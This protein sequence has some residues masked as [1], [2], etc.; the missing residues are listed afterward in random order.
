MT[1]ST[2]QPALPKVDASD[3]RKLRPP[4]C[5]MSALGWA[6]RRASPAARMIATAFIATPP[7]GPRGIAGA[8]GLRLVPARQIAAHP[9]GLPVGQAALP[10]QGCSI[11]GGMKWLLRPRATTALRRSVEP[12]RRG[13]GG[14]LL[15][16]LRLA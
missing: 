2:A 15:Y 4:S 14:G 7:H 16:G 1:P 3:W 5:S 10:S 6:I 13:L 11:E 8:T 12:A 9:R